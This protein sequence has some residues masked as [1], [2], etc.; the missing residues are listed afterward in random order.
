MKKKIITIVCLVLVFTLVAAGCQ[1]NKEDSRQYINTIG[2][3][4]TNELDNIINELYVYPIEGDARNSDFGED[5]G[6]DIIKNMNGERRVGSFG[7]T[8]EVSENYAVLARDREG[9]VYYFPNVNLQNYDVG[10]MSTYE[11]QFA[12]LLTHHDG[13]SEAIVGQYVPPDDAPD[14]TQN[15]LK[16]KVSYKFTITNTSDSELTLVTMREADDPE[17]GDVELSIDPIAAG[18]SVTASGDLY[19]E[20]QEI[21][22]WLLYI[23]TADGESQQLDGTFDPWTVKNIDIVKT[24]NDFSLKAS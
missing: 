13:T 8:V 5:M 22:N 17:K 18:K 12:L 19:E 16:K 1:K 9:G 15:P 21:T 20:D 10:I 23:E 7:T 3:V 4:F 24:G 6:P 11:E 2:V 14:H